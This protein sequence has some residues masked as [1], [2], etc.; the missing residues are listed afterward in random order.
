ML[1]YVMTPRHV[2]AGDERPDVVGVVTGYPHDPTGWTPSGRVRHESTGAA[3]HDPIT[4]AL[5]GIASR[6]P[7]DGSTVYDFKLRWQPADGELVAPGLFDV[8]LS[9]TDPSSRRHT[10]IAA[11]AV[12]S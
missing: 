3:L 6:D 1:R 9:V 7:G 11:L 4:V 5:E 12:R 8:L 2:L 10:F